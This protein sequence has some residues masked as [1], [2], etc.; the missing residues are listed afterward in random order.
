MLGDERRGLL[1]V[2]EE[3]RCDEGTRLSIMRIVGVGRGSEARSAEILQGSSAGAP[4]RCSPIV[5]NPRLRAALSFW[6]GIV[7]ITLFV[8][9]AIGDRD[10]K[11]YVP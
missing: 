10:E 8:P 2:L 4:I 11:R 3:M 5:T 7:L 6:G 1:H 9:M